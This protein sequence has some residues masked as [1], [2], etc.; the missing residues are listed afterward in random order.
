MGETIGVGTEKQYSLKMVSQTRTQNPKP[1]TVRWA[2][3]R[4][5]S[6]RPNMRSSVKYVKV[7]SDDIGTV[8]CAANLRA[9]SACGGIVRISTGAGIFRI[10][11][12]VGN[13]E[14]RLCLDH[15]S[16]DAA[17]ERLHLLTNIE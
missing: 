13:C 11:G 12:F 8:V 5:C 3:K 15:A 4:E 17:G 14:E 9:L 16:G 6:I 2:L 7:R 10:C 1:K